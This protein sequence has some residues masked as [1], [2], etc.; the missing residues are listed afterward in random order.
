MYNG[1]VQNRLVRLN[2]DG[3]LDTSFNI[4]TGFN[5]VV[6]VINIDTINQKNICWWCFYNNIMINQ[7][8]YIARLN[9]DGSL[10]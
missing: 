8:K 7:Q 9:M 2:M 6:W 5:N 4:G 3:S 10:G 1:N